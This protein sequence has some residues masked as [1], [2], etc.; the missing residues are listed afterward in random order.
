MRKRVAIGEPEWRTIPWRDIPKTPKDLLI[1]ILLDTAALLEDLDTLNA[2]P[3]RT[4]TEALA[5]RSELINKCWACD[6][7]LASWRAAVGI[8]DPSFAL[9]LAG[10]QT[11]PFSIDL[12]TASHILCVYWATSIIVYDALRILT[13]APEAALL[14]PHTDPSVYFRRIAEAIPVLLHPESGAYGVQLTNF[15]SLI[16]LIYT[17]AVGGGDVERE[18][19]FDAYRRAGK[20]EIVKRFH[21]SVGRQHARSPELAMMEGPGAEEARARSWLGM[22]KK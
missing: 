19:I 4:S 18:M 7:D 13:P 1:D 21:A 20:E 14:P 3:D 8:S 22:E 17:N 10:S 16:V 11:A 5:L 12:F 2:H 15:P 6:E 9:D